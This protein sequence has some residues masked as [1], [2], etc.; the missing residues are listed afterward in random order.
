MIQKM[1]LF[2]LYGKNK[3]FPET[4]SRLLKITKRYFDSETILSI[5]IEKDKDD[6]EDI[7][8]LYSFNLSIQNVKI[9]RALLWGYYYGW[10]RED[11]GD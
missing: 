3:S 10:K 7:I 9:A 11:F 2:S 5:E 1:E 6:G 8:T 4:M